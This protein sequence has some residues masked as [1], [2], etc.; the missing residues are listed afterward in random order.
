M[1]KGPRR[2]GAFWTS[3][4]PDDDHRQWARGRAQRVA[5]PVG[6]LGAD[7]RPRFRLKARLPRR[8][9]RR[10]RRPETGKH[11]EPTQP[12]DDQVVIGAPASKRALPLRG[13]V[14]RAEDCLA[15][16]S[17]N[18]SRPRKSVIRVVRRDEEAPCRRPPRTKESV[19]KKTSAMCSS[20][21]SGRAS[22]GRDPSAGRR[23]PANDNL[24]H[25]ARPKAGGGGVGSPGGR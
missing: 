15:R 7:C 18:H 4:G 1:W 11:A 23:R 13:P 10:R 5:G 6:G 16:G 9:L 19:V 24:P 25:G 3:R 17:R 12:A 20:A 2:R 21:H 22:A 14:D 8:L